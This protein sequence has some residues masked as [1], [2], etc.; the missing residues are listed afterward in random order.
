M[1]SVPKESNIFSV[2]KTPSTQDSKISHSFQEYE[3]S[4]YKYFLKITK[5][6]RTMNRR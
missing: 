5:K 1:P 3:F 6:Q 4:A 2:K